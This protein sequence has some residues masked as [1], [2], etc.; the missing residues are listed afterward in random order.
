VVGERSAVE[1]AR[2]ARVEE[3]VDRRGEQE[4]AA[5]IGVEERV[6]TERVARDCVGAVG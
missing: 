5:A 1:V 4:L 6:D 3:R 2:D